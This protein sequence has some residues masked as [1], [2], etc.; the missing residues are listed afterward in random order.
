MNKQSTWNIKNILKEIGIGVLLLFVVSNVISY[1][2]QPTIKSDSIPLFIEDTIVEKKI[3]TT[4]YKGKPLLI[5]IWATW[6]PTCRLENANIERISKQ[7]KVITIA[8]N[9][10][11]N[12][13]IQHYMKKN[14]FSFDVIN[15]KDGKLAKSFHIEAFPTT[16]IYDARGKLTFTEV[17]YSTTAGLL[18]RLK[19]IE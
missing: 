2:R 6:C 16:F 18:A 1:I 13:E 12:Q 9:S 17:G 3:D 14:Q 11:S 4:H 8:V 7:Y 10:G 15:D 19:L 5:H